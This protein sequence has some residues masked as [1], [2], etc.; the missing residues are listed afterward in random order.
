VTNLLSVL[1]EL[2]RSKTDCKLIADAMYDYEKCVIDPDHLSMIGFL[3]HERV[4]A[5]LRK[6][7]RDHGTTAA[8]RLAHKLKCKVRTHMSMNE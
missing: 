5:A 8:L 6:F 2:S 1:P 4:I 3:D 7:Y